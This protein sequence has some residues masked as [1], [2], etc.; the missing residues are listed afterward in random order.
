VKKGFLATIF[1]GLILVLAACGGSN[2][3]GNTNDGVDNSAEQ[4]EDSSSSENTT[5]NNDF[6]I[7]AT[8]WDFDQAEYVVEA[9]EEVNVTL[10]NEEGMHGIAI[11]D[12]DVKVDGDGEATFT[13]TEPGE[14]KIYCSVPC[15]QGHDDMTST[16]IVQ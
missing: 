6:E 10:V 16:L 8:N 3:D 5:A 13:P 12:L 1:L 11:D 9:G 7:K 2:N 14:Y 4:T 15:G